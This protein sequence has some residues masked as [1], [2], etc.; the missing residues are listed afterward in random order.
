MEH[1]GNLNQTTLGD[2]DGD[3]LAN[4][5]EYQAGTDPTAADTDGDGLNDALEL[6]FGN[7]PLSSN[8]YARLPFVENFETNTCA[9][10]DLNGQ[11]GWE[12]SPAG[13][14]LVQTGVVYEGRQALALNAGSGAAART[15]HL[16]A[17]GAESVVWLDFHTRAIPAA[18]AQP[19]SAGAMLFD[20]YGRLCLYD[21][22]LGRWINVGAK[23][24]EEG[25]WVRLTVKINYGQRTWRLFQDGIRVAD[26]AGFAE[27]FRAFTGFALEG[28]E[29]YVD[30]IGIGTSQPPSGDMDGDGLPDLAEADVYGTDPLNADSDGDGV[31]DGMELANGTNPLVADQGSSPNGPRVNIVS[32]AEGERILY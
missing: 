13:A 32:P 24:V 6:Y 3:G 15:R 25:T 2:L 26:N 17:P 27:D 8:A 19:G 22:Q 12:A 30:Q 28:Q 21:G 4:L 14:A 7:D 10:G 18:T 5:A 1:F 29:G 11:H 9:I 31:D 20:A 23:A 16:F